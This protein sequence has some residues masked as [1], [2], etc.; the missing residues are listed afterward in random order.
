[1][2]KLLNFLV[3]HKHR[4]RSQG[5][6]FRDLCEAQSARAR[7]MSSKLSKS[8][9]TAPVIKFIIV[10]TFFTPK[11]PKDPNNSF[12]FYLSLDP[13]TGNDPLTPIPSDS[14]L[15]VGD[16]IFTYSN[17]ANIT[18]NLVIVDEDKEDVGRTGEPRPFIVASTDVVILKADVRYQFYCQVHDSIEP[19]VR[20]PPMDFFVNVFE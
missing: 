4:D 3:T 14:A 2:T 10:F 5:H 16:Y 9:K 12:K 1:M 19:G 8:N 20:N 6:P 11:A 7:A 13:K 15:P 17:R 18:H